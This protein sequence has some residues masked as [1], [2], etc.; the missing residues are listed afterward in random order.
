MV[1]YNGKKKTCDLG[2][3]VDAR[4]GA[5]QVKHPRREEPA[6][7]RP[8]RTVHHHEWPFFATRCLP[9]LLVQKRWHLPEYRVEVIVRE[10][11]E[12]QADLL[13]PLYSIQWLAPDLMANGADGS[14]H[15]GQRVRARRAPQIGHTEAAGHGHSK[16]LR[17]SLLHQGCQPVLHVALQGRQILAF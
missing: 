3:P 10:I 12:V 5:D 14:R 16:Q 1:K 6:V 15:Q 8:G 13:A 7:E 11:I 4:R 17:H 9:Q 2:E